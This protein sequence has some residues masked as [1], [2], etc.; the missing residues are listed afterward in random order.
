VHDIDP[1]NY[2]A[3][4]NLGAKS[5]R[6]EVICLLND[7][8][9]PLRSDWLKLMLGELSDPAVGAVGARLLYPNGWV[10]H[11]GLVIGMMGRAEHWQRLSRRDEPGYMGRARATQD[12]SAVTGACLMVRSA[13][14]WALNGL[15]EGFAISFNDVDFCLRL[16]EDDWRIVL[17]AEAELTHNETASLDFGAPRLAQVVAEELTRFRLRW[18]RVM[19]NDPHFNPNLSLETAVGWALAVPPRDRESRLTI[20]SARNAGRDG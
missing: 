13:L 5:A 8:V 10:Q 14:F 18:R 6:G 12:V 17:C 20:V 19:F 16:R 4:N 15:D 1:F 11:M 2:A 9:K 7:D 3:V